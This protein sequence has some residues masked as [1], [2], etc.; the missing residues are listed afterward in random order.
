MVQLF[1]VVKTKQMS[2]KVF[3]FPNWWEGS[4]VYCLPFFQPFVGLDPEE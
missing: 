3:N 1:L 4:L 2:D